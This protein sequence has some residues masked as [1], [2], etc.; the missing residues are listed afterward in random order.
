MSGQKF[1]LRKE[2]FIPRS[3]S[4]LTL[5]K[6]ISFNKKNKKL[7]I[8]GTLLKRKGTYRYNLDM[9]EEGQS[10]RINNEL[11]EKLEDEVTKL[12]ILGEFNRLQFNQA[13]EFLEEKITELKN[14][15][16]NNNKIKPLEYDVSIITNSAEQLV[17]WFE[18]EGLKLPDSAKS[19]KKIV[20]EL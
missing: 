2:N 1:I 14:A 9:N 20:A 6:N 16:G 13:V 12:N 15:K 5:Y 11:L 7:T 3:I 17:E 10:S 18:D 4:L 8:V 19:Y